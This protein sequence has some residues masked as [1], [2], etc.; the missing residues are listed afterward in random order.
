MKDTDFQYTTICFGL[1]LKKLVERVSAFD[2]H[3]RLNWKG[4]CLF[5]SLLLLSFQ[6]TLEKPT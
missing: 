5:P 2:S 3:C 6:P 1:E 4:L